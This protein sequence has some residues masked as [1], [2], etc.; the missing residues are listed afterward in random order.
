MLRTILLVFTC[1][2]IIGVKVQSIGVEFL[3]FRFSFDSKYLFI[4]EL[5]FFLD[6]DIVA[7]SSESES[8]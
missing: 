7:D 4:F 3:S 5:Y 1:R 6:G 8:L 2:L